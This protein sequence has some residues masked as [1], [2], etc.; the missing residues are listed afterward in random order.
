MR[1]SVTIKTRWNQ[2]SKMHKIEYSGKFLIILKS[3]GLIHS[4]TSREKKLHAISHKNVPRNYDNAVVLTV[5]NIC[6]ELFT[7]KVHLNS[8]LVHFLN[9]HVY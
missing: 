9:T 2:A 7:L 6:T 5:P 4:K 8:P 3:A 1:T